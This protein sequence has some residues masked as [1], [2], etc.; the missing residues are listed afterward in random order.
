MGEFE[1]LGK[2]GQGGM[3]AVY[4][5]RQIS[6]DRQVA[7]K[8]LPQHLEHDAEYVGRFQREARVAANLHHPNLVRVYSYGVVGSCHYIAM[9]LIEGETLADWL[10]RGS[11]PALE[12][13]RIILPV[14]QA[15]E[16]GWRTAQLIHRDVKPGNIFLSTDGEVKLGDLGLA[17]T[18]GSET[19]GLTQTG[20]MMGTPH[21]ISPEQ[22][23]GDRDLDFRADIY[24]LGCTLY[25]MLTGKTPY[26]GSDPLAVM[27]LHR[28]GPPPAIL[29]ALPQCPI[30]LARLV[31]KMLKKQR[32]ERHTSY[33]ELI[34]NLEQVQAA[35]DPSFVAPAIP[36][37][38]SSSPVH[39]APHTPLPVESGAGHAKSATQNQSLQTS[40]PP[41]AKSRLPI[42]IV[43]GTVSLAVAAYLIWPAK[44]KLTV[45]ERYV[46]D[47]AGERK[48]LSPAA[49]TATSSPAA[50]TLPVDSNHT[51]SGSASASDWQ[52][53]FTE[54]E[55]HKA[56]NKRE[57]KDGLLHLGSLFG[58]AQPSPD[59]A[60][61]A[62][63]AIGENSNTIALIVRDSGTD[64]YYKFYT[65]SDGKTGSL[66]Y[67]LHGESA[68][69]SLLGTF[70]LKR[71]LELGDK[72]VLEL[73]AQ[74]DH[75]V[76]LVNGAVAVDVHDQHLKGAGRW[77]V[78]S[79]DGWFESVEVQAF[80][81]AITP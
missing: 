27:S 10:R 65:S 30:P 50:S 20:A 45:A 18:L 62:R 39:A 24:S 55:W 66:G 47:H 64:G 34:A 54:E 61:R 43:V 29:K 13:V 72:L 76:G 80:P 28:D 19:T 1:V 63:V 71:P 16:C 58:K 35:L 74:G 7:L 49:W 67:C 9:E 11:L 41:K 70:P 40:A 52:P 3:G 2:L 4:R 38:K 44:Q 46:R 32:R 48:E 59:G 26:S 17:K 15:L 57:F 6:L 77:G 75:L 69:N 79:L 12:A 78:S 14:V 31:G 22:A 60:I 68:S 42:Y 8:L 53:L 5:A 23:R 25:H 51:N 33:D 37:A 56:G 21:Y 36:S 73:R 81:P